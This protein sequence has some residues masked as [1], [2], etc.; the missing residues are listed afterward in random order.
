MGDRLMM[1]AQELGIPEAWRAALGLVLGKLER[2]ELRHVDLETFSQVP[3]GD[4]FNMNWWDNDFI[5]TTKDCGTVACIGGWAEK[6]GGVKFEVEGPL[7]LEENHPELE[8]LF[9]PRGTRDYDHIDAEHAATALRNYL[10]GGRA[11]W[12]EVMGAD[13]Q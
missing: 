10:T 12:E 11:Q 5:A 13:G 1:T 4:W 9:Y 7:G 2:G 3:R 8:K 6:L